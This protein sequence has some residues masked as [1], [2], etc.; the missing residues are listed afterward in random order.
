MS[1]EAIS[2]LLK[3]LHTKLSG[4]N[5]FTAE[6]RALLKQLAADIQALLAQPGEVTHARRQTVT[7]QLMAAV[8]RFEVSHPELTATLAQVSTKLGDM[9]I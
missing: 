8:T 6:D 4:S 3:E 9:G 5:S 7:D 1:H 2:N